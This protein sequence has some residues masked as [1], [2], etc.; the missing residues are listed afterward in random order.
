MLIR[1]SLFFLLVAALAGCSSGESAL[2]EGAPPL[3]NVSGQ[4]TYKNSPVSDA[5]VVFAPKSGKVGASARTDAEG[6]FTA[7]AF[8]PHKGMP[9]GD[10]FVTVTKTESVEVPGSDPNNKQ[11]KTKYLIPEKF[12]NASKSGLSVTVTSQGNE[13]LQLDLKD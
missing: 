5:I 12:G 1:T 13:N 8:P 9:E 7:Q 4:V 3:Y 10:F 11:T 2:P 6:K